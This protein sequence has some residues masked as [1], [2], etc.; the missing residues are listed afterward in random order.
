MINIIMTLNISS[1]I[2]LFFPFFKESFTIMLIISL[3]FQSLSLFA[4]FL[5]HIIVFFL[6]WW[7]FNNS[8][9]FNWMTCLTPS[10][11]IKWLFSRLYLVPLILLSTLSFF[12]V[13]KRLIQYMFMYVFNYLVISSLF[14]PIYQEWTNSMLVWIIAIYLSSLCALEIKQSWTRWFMRL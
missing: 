3:W 14:I 10:L 1:F 9:I 11:Q 13:M 7:M 4:W 5:S 6:L 8:N 2:I 12:I